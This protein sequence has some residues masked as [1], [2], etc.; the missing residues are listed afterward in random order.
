MGRHSAGA[1]D[2]R[3]VGRVLK[4]HRRASCS[5]YSSPP[6]RDVCTCTFHQFQFSSH[7]L[8]AEAELRL[9]MRCS[10]TQYLG[11]ACRVCWVSSALAAPPLSFRL[12]Y[13]FLGHFS[14]FVREKRA[15][16]VGPWAARGGRCGA[17][18]C[19]RRRRAEPRAPP[20]GP[21]AAH[22]AEHRVVPG[23][24]RANSGVRTRTRAGG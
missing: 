18:I 16:K 20:P 13:G 3:S 17:E 21:D 7:I 10:Q 5:S 19:G 14:S 2:H 6:L 15:G 12:I 22:C 11:R 24:C 4:A 23:N 9:L 1:A 8:I